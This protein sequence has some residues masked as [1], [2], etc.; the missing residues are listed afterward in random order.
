MPQTLS[1]LGRMHHQVNDVGFIANQP[2]TNTTVQCR[3]IVGMAQMTKAKTAGTIRAGRI[4][5]GATEFFEVGLLLPIATQTEV[6]EGEQR[7]EVLKAERLERGSH[8]TS[9]LNTANSQA[10]IK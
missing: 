3:R 5:G 10:L 2:G 7:F 1:P 9:R 8:R 4:T 6:I